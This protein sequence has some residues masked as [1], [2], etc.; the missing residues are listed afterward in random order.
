[1]LHYILTGRSCKSSTIP[2]TNKWS[3]MGKLFFIYIVFHCTT[4]FSASSLHLGISLVF[5]FHW[6]LPECA[7]SL[8]LS[9]SAFLAHWKDWMAIKAWERERERDWL[10]RIDSQQGDHRKLRNFTCFVCGWI[11]LIDTFL[12]LNVYTGFFLI[13]MVRSILNNLRNH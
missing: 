6:E 8:S 12:W 5:K 11:S 7:L 3:P 9:L 13:C 10:K 2:V 4:F 1:M